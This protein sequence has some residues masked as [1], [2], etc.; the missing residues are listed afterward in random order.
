MDNAD[1]EKLKV[2]PGKLVPRFKASVTE[3]SVTLASSVEEIKFSPLTSDSGASYTVKVRTHIV[4]ELLVLK[5][6]S[7]CHTIITYPYLVVCP[8][9]RFP[10]NPDLPGYNYSCMQKKNA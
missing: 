10:V 9:Q 1:L 7:E 6:L 4:S 2:S 3:Y 5:T 8:W